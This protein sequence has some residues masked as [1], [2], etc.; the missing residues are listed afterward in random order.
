MESL[1]RA[2]LNPHKSPP[3]HSTVAQALVHWKKRSACTKPDDWVFASRR[4]RGRKPYWGQAILRKYI[5]PVALHLGIQ[6]RFGWHTFSHTY[7]TLLRSGNRVQSD[8]RITAA[9]KF[10]IHVGR[11][12]SGGHSS[13]ACSASG[14][15]VVGPFFLWKRRSTFCTTE[16]GSRIAA[17]RAQKGRETRPFSALDGFKRTRLILL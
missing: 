4:C 2:R 6:K 7:S 3:L 9:F 5:R 8:A 16:R 13:E 14:G 17:K 11:L 1:E 10:A 15:R 12:H